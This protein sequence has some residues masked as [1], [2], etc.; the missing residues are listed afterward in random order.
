MSSSSRKSLLT[1][2][3]ECF[4]ELGIEDWFLF[5]SST[6]GPVSL[7]GTPRFPVYLQYWSCEEAEWYLVGEKHCRCQASHKTTSG[8]LTE[9]HRNFMEKMLL[10]SPRRH[11]PL[12]RWTH[13]KACKFI[14]GCRFTFQRWIP[15]PVN[16][17][18]ALIFIFV[19]EVWTL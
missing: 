1:S 13:E 12:K 18:L 17:H 8:Y 3:P 19:S 15:L 5:P 4:L 10:P 6:L 14:L 9:T 16:L 2:A 7:E 11:H